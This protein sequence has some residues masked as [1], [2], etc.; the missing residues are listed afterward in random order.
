MGQTAIGLQKYRLKIN[1]EV[2]TTNL[3]VSGSNPF[4][5]AKFLALGASDS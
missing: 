3:G 4:G 2:L 5:R 1:E